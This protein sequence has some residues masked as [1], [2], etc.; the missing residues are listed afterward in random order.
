MRW[1]LLDEQNGRRTYA[2]VFD[3][4]EE[5]VAGLLDFARQHRLYG[6]QLTAIGALSSLVLGYFELDR[7]EFKRIRVD[8]QVEVLSLVGNFAV[9]EDAPRLHAHIVVGYADGTARGG[10]LFEARVRPTLE[11]LLT[12]GPKH[13]ERQYDPETGLALLRW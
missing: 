1:R 9:H 2:V 4:G 7:K 10:H 13:L 8:E 5:A 11:V 12:D 3:T 6:S